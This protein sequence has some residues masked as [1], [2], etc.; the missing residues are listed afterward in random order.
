MRV[1]P[2]LQ[3]CGN[4][5][6]QKNLNMS[7]HMLPSLLFQNRVGTSYSRDCIQTSVNI[8]I[9]ILLASIPNIRNQYESMPSYFFHLLFELYSSD[10]LK[11]IPESEG[12]VIE[13]PA[14]S[15]PCFLPPKDFNIF[16]TKALPDHTSKKGSL[17]K[18]ADSKQSAHG[19]EEVEL[20]PA[21]VERQKAKQ[22]VHNNT[23]GGHR[24]AHIDFRFGRVSVESVDIVA[25]NSNAI[26]NSAQEG[27]SMGPHRQ[28]ITNSL[29][30]PSLAVSYSAAATTSTAEA[31]ISPPS[32]NKQLSQGRVGAVSSPLKARF[33]VLNPKTT[34]F[35][36]GVVHLYRDREETEGIYPTPES[37]NGS[38]VGSAVSS[39]SPSLSHNTKPTENGAS[40]S[41]GV[42]EALKTVAILAVP[43]YM[44]ASD[45]MGFVGEETRENASHFRMIRTGQANRYMVLVRFREAEKA[46][47]F[48]KSFNGKVF[49]SME[50]S[51]SVTPLTLKRYID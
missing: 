40:K 26:S 20:I 17:K 51:D 41:N 33:I 23:A 10:F 47:V 28:P 2:I 45:F 14:K 48:V 16:N 30:K 36:Y 19:E 3:R 32:P 27:T 49:N 12:L 13:V 15:G 46:R 24:G 50:V 7:I 4:G 37:V 44:T 29:L 35:G 8:N 21:S 11:S 39:S 6:G 9:L 18:L 42:E 38:T 1:N 34:E 43:S 25:I 22:S 31:S 5:K